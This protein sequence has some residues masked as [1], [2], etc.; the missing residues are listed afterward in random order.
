[1]SKREQYMS[2]WM[3]Q[4]KER[5]AD[6]W[7]PTGRDWYF[8]RLGA[9]NALRRLKAEWQNMNHIYRI[10]RYVPEGGK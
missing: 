5:G 8:S 6:W 1:M 7:S 9:R 3:I 2:I 10:C 4:T